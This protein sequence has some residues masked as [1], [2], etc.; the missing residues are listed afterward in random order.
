[1]LQNSQIK[2]SVKTRQNKYLFCYLSCALS[3]TVYSVL[4]G[5]LIL[6]FQ[7]MV[8]LCKSRIYAK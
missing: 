8:V 1:M 5:P 4:Y 6:F 7:T 2:V 3:C